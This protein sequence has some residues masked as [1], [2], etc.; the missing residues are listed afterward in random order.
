MSTANQQVIPVQAHWCITG[1]VKHVL[2]SILCAVKPSTMLHRQVR[3][4]KV[5]LQQHTAG[6][7]CKAVAQLS[8]APSHHTQPAQPLRTDHPQVPQMVSAN[9]KSITQGASLSLL[10]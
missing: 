8:K 5:L 9:L 4:W 10:A 7:L 1:D 3:T 2:Q 6:E